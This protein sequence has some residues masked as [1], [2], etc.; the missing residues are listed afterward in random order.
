[1]EMSLIRAMQTYSSIIRF[2]GL[3]HNNTMPAFRY[4]K[5]ANALNIVMD[6]RAPCYSDA[7]YQCWW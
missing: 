1:M 2:D 4:S 3:G 6:D 7:I 5:H